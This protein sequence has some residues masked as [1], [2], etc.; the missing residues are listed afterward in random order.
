MKRRIP[1]PQI[2]TKHFNERKLLLLLA[3]WKYGGINE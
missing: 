1:Y 3:K 2:L